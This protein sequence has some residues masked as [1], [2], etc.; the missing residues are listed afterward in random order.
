MFQIKLKKLRKLWRGVEKGNKKNQPV[1]IEFHINIVDINNKTHLYCILI[2]IHASHLET[3][4]LSQVQC[5]SLLII[6]K[7]NLN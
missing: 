7:F 3:H 1:E 6:N 5:I 4:R 2:F